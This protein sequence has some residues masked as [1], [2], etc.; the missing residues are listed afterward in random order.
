MKVFLPFGKNSNNYIEEINAYFKGD[1]VYGSYR[2][3]KQEYNIVNIHWPEA[4]FEW[5]DVSDKDLVELEKNIKQWKQYSKIVYTRHNREP[6]NK[7]IK[8][9]KA[10]YV[11]ILKYCDGIIHL[12]DFSLRELLKNYPKYKAKIN[13]VIPHPLYLKNKKYITQE[14]AREKFSIKVDAKVVL[15]FGNIRT[16]EEKKLILKAFNKLKTDNKLLLV[17]RMPYFLEGVP[18]WR[19]KILMKQIVRF[20]YGLFSKY[21]FFYDFV[22]QED[23]PYFVSAADIVFVPRIKHLNSGNVYLGFSYNKP[24]VG[25]AV[26]NIKEVLNNDFNYLFDPKNI[27]SV[28]NALEKGLKEDISIVHEK[29]YKENLPNLVAKKYFEFFLKVLHG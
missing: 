6:H 10:L 1:F 23:I 24:I 26:G 16:K 2:D 5:Q 17:S 29:V 20:Y 25:P 21:K 12:G 4:L 18:S 7:G 11:I 27:K 15:V 3:Y 28:T 8:N 13:A 22:K 14:Q 19:L 9:I